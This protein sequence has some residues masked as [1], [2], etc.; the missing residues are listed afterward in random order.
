VA[1]VLGVPLGHV[2]SAALLR[3]TSRA[4]GFTAALA[5]P[6]SLLPVVVVVTLGMAGAAAVAPARRAA[7]LDPVVAL[8]FE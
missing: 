8:R 2:L 5:F 6:W 4:L 3:G 1:L 7:R